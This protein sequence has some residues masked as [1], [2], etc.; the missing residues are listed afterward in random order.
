MTKNDPVNHPAHYTQYEHEVIEL[1]EKLDF[2]TGNAVKYILRAPFKGNEKQDLEKALWYLKHSLEMDEPVATGWLFMEELVQS[3][4]NDI[5]STLLLSDGGV[6]LAM[7]KIGDR[8]KEIENAETMDTINR[9]QKEVEQLRKDNEDLRRQ[10]RPGY[11][12]PSPIWS[13]SDS[14]FKDVDRMFNYIKRGVYA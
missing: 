9:L 6:R 1:T 8:L 14:T 11:I 13:W 7:I 12:D 2:C 3:Y 5:V 4:K 10:S